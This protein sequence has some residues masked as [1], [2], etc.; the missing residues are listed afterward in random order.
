MSMLGRVADAIV[1]SF[2]IT[3]PTEAKRRQAGM[4]IL[5]LILLIVAGFGVGAWLLVEKFLR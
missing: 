5:G 3:A 1:L 4:Y 2:G